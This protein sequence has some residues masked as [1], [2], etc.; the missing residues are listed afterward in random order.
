MMDI[1]MCPLFFQCT[2][3]VHPSPSTQYK[4]WCSGD[5]CPLLTRHPSPPHTLTLSGEGVE[6]AATLQTLCHCGE[7]NNITHGNHTPAGADPAAGCLRGFSCQTGL[8]SRRSRD[9]HCSPP[10]QHSHHITCLLPFDRYSMYSYRYSLC[11]FLGQCFV[12]LA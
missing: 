11:L 5:R 9:L 8:S 10:Y 4:Q 3:I 6:G 1:P 2:L 12:C 7:R